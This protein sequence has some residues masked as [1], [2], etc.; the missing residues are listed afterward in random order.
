[1]KETMN[2]AIDKFMKDNFPPGFDQLPEI[3]QLP[4]RKHKPRYRRKT[5]EEL[6][7]WF[8]DELQ[9]FNEQYERQLTQHFKKQGKR[10]LA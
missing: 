2:E 3:Y 9:R 1:M 8:D 6:D 4:G 5:N 10:K 7:E